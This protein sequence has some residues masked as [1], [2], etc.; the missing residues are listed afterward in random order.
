MTYSIFNLDSG[1]LIDSYR[2]ESR[3]L[4]LIAEILDDDENDPEALGLIVFARGKEV[5]QISG[6]ALREAAAPYSRQINDG[7]DG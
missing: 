6:D 4:A 1:N 3:A 7:P 2:S 5:R